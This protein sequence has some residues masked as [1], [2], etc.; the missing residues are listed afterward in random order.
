MKYHG[1]LNKRTYLLSI[2]PGGRGNCPQTQNIWAKPKFSGTGNK[3]YQQNQ[4]FSTPTTN[5]SGTKACELRTI[6]IEVK[7]FLYIFLVFTNF[8]A[9]WSSGLSA[10]IV[11]DM[12]SVLNLLAPFCFVLGKD[13]SFFIFIFIF[14]TCKKAAEAL[15][16]KNRQA[17]TPT[18]FGRCQILRFA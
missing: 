1:L 17:I 10:E 11:I 18:C 5:Y 8:S 3:L 2:E 7:T 6:Q 9:A 4:K 15:I 12:V 16:F 13:T 14:L